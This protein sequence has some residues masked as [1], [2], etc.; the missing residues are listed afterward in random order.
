M[1]E[2]EL[3]FLLKHVQV[4]EIDLGI[5]KCWATVI[6]PTESYVYDE[7]LQKKS[8]LRCDLRDFEQ[9]IKA[10]K[11]GFWDCCSINK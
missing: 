8:D 2:G 4:V 9:D 10:K 5:P 1:E 11:K 6:N 3:S 7:L